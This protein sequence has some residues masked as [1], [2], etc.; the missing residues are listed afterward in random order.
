MK[1]EL[2]YLLWSLENEHGVDPNA[3]LIELIQ[4]LIKQEEEK[5]SRGEISEER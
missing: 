4:L 1:R 5:E 2:E 3:A